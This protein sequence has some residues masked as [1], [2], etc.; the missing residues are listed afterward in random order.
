MGSDPMKVSSFNVILAELLTGAFVSEFNHLCIC[1]CVGGVPKCA[2]QHMGGLPRYAGKQNQQTN[3]VAK[4]FRTAI[5]FV[6]ERGD[7]DSHKQIVGRENMAAKCC[8]LKK[9]Q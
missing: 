5:D 8:C 1:V 4:I 9:E 3:I 2:E 7:P 6:S